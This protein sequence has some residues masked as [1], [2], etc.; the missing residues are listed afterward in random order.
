VEATRSIFHD[1]PYGCFGHAI[2]IHS[3]RNKIK[4]DLGTKML[5]LLYPAMITNGAMSLPAQRR[6]VDGLLERIE[7]KDYPPLFRMFDFSLARKAFGELQAQ[8][9]KPRP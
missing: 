8:G 1:L 3:A 7:K 2:S 5:E 6:V 9:W 4:D